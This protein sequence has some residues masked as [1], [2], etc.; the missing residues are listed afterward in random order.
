MK[1]VILLL[2]ILFLMGSIGCGTIS[3]SVFV[4]PKPPEMPQEPSYYSVEW[5]DCDGN[6]CLDEENAGNL[7]KNKSLIDDFVNQLKATIKKFQ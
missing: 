3:K 4:K 6:Y 2:M 7:L 5:K 1:K